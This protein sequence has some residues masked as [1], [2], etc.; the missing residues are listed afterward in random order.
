MG[1]DKALLP[2][3]GQPLASY[4]AR[5]VAAAAETAVLVGD[6]ARLT[7][8]GYP[9]I[10]DLYP[11]EGPLGGILTALDHTTAD[12]NLLTACDMPGLT[13]AFLAGLLTA[14]EE[15]GAD[16]LMPAG[17]SGLPEPLCAVYRRTGRDPIARAFAGGVRKV[18]A[19]FAGLRTV[20]LSVPELKPF[21]NVNTPQDWAGYAAG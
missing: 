13:A 15:S 18:T 2:F 12:W 8:L 17:P 5:T 1:R 11:G 14:A 16:I 9:V 7:G 10:P 4:V 20:Q 21:Q 3:H 6:E 19:A